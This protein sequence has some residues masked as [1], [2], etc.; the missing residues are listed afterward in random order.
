VFYGETVC[1]ILFRCREL[2]LTQFARA[3]TTVQI[4]LWM[5]EKYQEKPE[6]EVPSILFVVLY[7]KCLLKT[8]KQKITTD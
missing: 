6:H 7:K 5:K 2:V 1:C 4:A 3:L 8:K